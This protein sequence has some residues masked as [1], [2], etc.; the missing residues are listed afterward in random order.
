MCPFL[1]VP[2][3]YAPNN[4]WFIRTM[5]AV[6]SVGGDTMHPDI[7]NSFLRLLAEGFE[8]E[9]EDIQLRFH[10]VQSYLS[11]LEDKNAVYPQKFLQVM[12]WVLGEYSYLLQNV[13]PE[14]VLAS[15]FR[16]L[17]SNATCETKAWIAAA[18]SK[19]ASRTNG[20]KTVEKFLLEFT[21]NFEPYG[22][23]LSRS[24]PVSRITGRQSPTGVSLSSDNSVETG[25]K[26]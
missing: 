10:A 9:K 16:I 11:L 25:Q 20:S 23:S 24:F 21:L 18:I 14:V 22:E 26:E 2:G 12:S 1:N 19:I 15:L 4:E 7:L 8:D 17:K 3:T 6:F 5:N 13:D